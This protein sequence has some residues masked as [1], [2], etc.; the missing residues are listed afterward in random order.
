MMCRVCGD[1]VP[2][3]DFHS[4]R[5][6]ICRPCFRRYQCSAMKRP[7]QALRRKFRQMR[8]RCEDAR[9]PYY[10]LYGGKGICV[11]WTLNSFRDWAL[12]NG[13]KPGLFIDRID[14]NGHYCPE[15]CRFVTSQESGQNTSHCKL[16]A[17][18][19]V[20]IKELSRDGLGNGQI[21]RTLNLPYRTIWRVTRGDNWDNI[22]V[23]ILT[24]VPLELAR[25][26]TS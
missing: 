18:L 9:H 26:R 4:S 14:A 7:L 16:N 23:P 25:G 5:G 11:L 21:G 3:K 2:K 12:L 8:Q 13:W 20:K 17:A 22:T 19:V 6:H 1:P 15:N 10:Y 24:G